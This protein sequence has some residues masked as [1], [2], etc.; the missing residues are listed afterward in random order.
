MK[1]LMDK[2]RL[3]ILLLFCSSILLSQKKDDDKIATE[4]VI[5][6]KSYTPILNEAFKIKSAP[7][8]PNSV[9]SPK[10][11]ILYKFKDIPVVSTFQP[12]KA[13][14]LKLKQRKASI[15]FNTIFSGAYGNKNQLY[16]NV[17]SVVE[18]DRK[19]RFGFRFYND[20]FS[21]NL[22]NTLLKSNQNYTDFGLHH[23]LRSSEYNVNTHLKFSS[24]RDNYFGL[25]KNI[26]DR[27]LLNNINPE[28]IRNNFKFR[29]HWNWYNFFLRGIT[30]Q[31]NITSDNF[32]TLEQ[33]LALKNDFQ[34]ELGPGK[35]KGELKLIGFNTY[36]ESSFFEKSIQEFTQGL[37]EL[38]LFW[39]S[40]KSDLKIKFGGG[41]GYLLG[42]NEISNNIVYYPHI[43]LL[44]QKPGNT[45]LPYL[46]GNG[47]ITFNT[48]NSLSKENPYLAPT[49][50][51]TPS[52]N[53]YNLNI[54]IRSRLASILNFDMGFIFDKIE[55][56]S[57]FERLPY[58]NK[59]NLA[60]FRL[61]NSF[62][63][64]YVDTDL[65][66]FRA[67]IRIDLVKDNF[68][69]FETRYNHFEIEENLTLWNIP[70]LEMNWE[71]QIKLRDFVALSFNGSLWGVRDSSFRPIFFEQ[72]LVDAQAIPSNTE[73]L[74]FFF[75]T[76]THITFKIS[77]QFDLF[78]KG[79]FNSAGIHGR[80]AY[81]PEAP[82]LILGGLTYKFDFQY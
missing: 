72:D 36:F 28:V 70:S 35:L 39:H 24:N 78:I 21:N 2:F 65:Y 43:E 37:G 58:D 42:V 53:K 48:Y 6:I 16:L 82:L 17:S 40:N 15:P 66:G 34:I 25:Y 69:R 51:L 79:R 61:S 11:N 54:G 38:D 47:G 26:W 1:K 59:N 3:F 12:N 13:S 76:S 46:K 49:S 22:N 80:W 30:F 19:Q 7:I 77:E 14:P 73:T 55:N 68:V 4:E 33:Q 27:F 64:N 56:F 5:V 62:H 57:Y 63:S 23:N 81:Y 71:S 31:A 18:L 8:I 29:T 45:L 10:K 20:G 52:L 44:Y 9:F 50:N 60:P 32:N 75:R 41:I 74:P 67:S